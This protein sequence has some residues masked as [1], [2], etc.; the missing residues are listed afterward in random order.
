MRKTDRI[1]RALA[2]A[3]AAFV[4]APG[5]VQAD[6]HLAR[7]EVGRRDPGRRELPPGLKISIG[8]SFSRVD[9]NS[10]FGIGTRVGPGGEL[11]VTRTRGYIDR[12]GI[13]LGV[14]VPH[15]GGYMLGPSS[16]GMLEVRFS[17]ARGEQKGAGSA[18][19]GQDGVTQIG[20]TFLEAEAPPPGGPGTGTG[21]TVAGDGLEAFARNDNSWAL[22]TLAYCETLEDHPRDNVDF[23]V[24][25]V[26]A[27][28]RLD[29]DFWAQGD[30]VR[31]G[32]SLA[33]QKTWGST[34]DSYFGLGAR[35]GVT[36]RF[37][38]KLSVNLEGEIVPS[39][40][41]GEASLRQVSNFSGGV[42]QELNHSDSGFTVSGALRAGIN[43]SLSE[44]TSVSFKYEYSR[45]G[46]VTEVHVPQNPD[47]QPAFFDSGYI[48]R[49]FARAE[50]N[51]AL[52]SDIRLKRD[53]VPLAR[54]DNGLRLYRYRYLW[55]DTLY[56]GVM[57]QE[58]A[59]VIPEAVVRGADGFLR[60]DYA[61]LGLGLR[62]WDEWAGQRKQA[63]ESPAIEAGAAL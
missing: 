58:V 16:R 3:T 10:R 48:E 53:I 60:V 45:L 17:Y 20:L 25:V 13:D 34:E 51:M 54:L 42:T 22:A 63:S 27:F 8:G 62:T 59:S 11:F 39:Y 15:S 9:V 21:S 36:Y 29:Q 18:T 38:P 46:A 52:P 57:A 23:Q 40:H 19:V 14:E 43:W 1:T 7:R 49:H 56:V 5:A 12:G 31:G 26:G 30:I 28:E 35:V 50:F 2:L 33:H 44:R 41:K 4:S 61:R 32:D 6:S 24:G 55:S 37:N 47:E